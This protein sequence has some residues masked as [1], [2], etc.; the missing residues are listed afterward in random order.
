MPY[1]YSEVD[2]LLNKPLVG[3]GS[4]VDLIKRLVP[5][6]AGKPTTVWKEGLNVMDAYKAG[7]ILPRGTAIAT[8]EKGRYLQNCATNYIG[9]CHHAALLLQVMSGGIWVMDQFTGVENRQFVTRRFIRVPMPRQQKFA[10]GAY[11]DA[12][13]NALAFSVIEQ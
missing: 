9:S 5:G 3:S 2:Q 12:G 1:S 6:L 10:D 11:R 7:K 8:F 4:C 13:N